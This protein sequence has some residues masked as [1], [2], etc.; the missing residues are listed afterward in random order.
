MTLDLRPCAG[1]AELFDTAVTG[2][3]AE[4]MATLA[5]QPQV[6]PWCGYIG[7]DGPVP[8]GFGGF[9][10]WWQGLDSI[11]RG[12]FCPVLVVVMQRR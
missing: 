4:Q 7:W 5:E 3:F 10:W 8:V 12:G 2:Q 1:E 11:G 6:P 9:V